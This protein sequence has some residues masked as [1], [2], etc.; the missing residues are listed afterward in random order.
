MK[1]IRISPRDNVAVALQDIAKGETI[2]TDEFSVT[3]EEPV[4]RGHKIALCDIPQDGDIVKYGNVIAKASAPITQEAGFIPIT[5]TPTSKRAEA[6]ATIIKP[7][8]F[9]RLRT[10]ALWAS[11]EKTAR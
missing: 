4:P 10:E 7:S 11:E 6:I 1:L 8:L 5:P 3:S 9:R 2:T